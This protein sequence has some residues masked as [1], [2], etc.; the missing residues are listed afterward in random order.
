[1]QKS[2]FVFL[3][4]LL[5]LTSVDCKKNSGGGSPVTADTYQ[6]TTTGSEW[7]YTTTG[8][9]AGTFKLTATATDTVIN[10]HTYRI[11]TNNNGQNIY[12]NKSGNE[13]YRYGRFAELNNESL[14][15][16][17]LKDN[18]SVG[19]SWTETK[20]VNATVTGYGTIPVTA[21]FVFTVAEKEITH[22]VGSLTF[23]NVIK[24]TAV[25]SFSAYLASIPVA[26]ST[27]EYYYAKNIGLVH[28]IT[29][30]N[31]PA[32]SVNFSSETKLTSYSIK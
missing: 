32:A 17:Y 9:G 5:M 2:T 16:L 21:V 6:P 29:A 15:L 14:E 22:V 19:Q 12:Y 8:S 7:N 27:L 23:S 18:L 13:Y 1:M 31:I 28:S 3:A 24:V 10:S 26:S 30:L 20:T 25:P 11:C 4:L